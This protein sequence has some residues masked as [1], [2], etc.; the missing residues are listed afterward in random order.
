MDLKRFATRALYATLMTGGLTLLGAGVA[1]AAETGGDD[2]IASGTQT[3]ISIDLPIT[4]AGNGLSVLGDSSSSGAETAT[5][6]DAQAAS[7]AAEPPATSGDDGVGSGTQAL[8]DVSIPVTLGG[9]AISVLG[10]SASEGASTA[11]ATTDTEGAAAGGGEPSGTSGDDAVLG[12]TQVL[13]DVTLPVTVGGNAI[14]VLGDSSSTGSNS[15]VDG[16]GD[17][18]T[19]GATTGGSEAVLGGTQVLP[20]VTL[21][22]TVGGNA[23]SIVGDAS[24]TGSNSTVDGPGD[25]ATGGATTGGSEAVLGGTQVLPDVTLPVTVGGNAVSIVGDS[26]STGSNSTVDGPGDAATGGATTGG[27]DGVLGGTQLIPVVDVPITI[28]GNAISVLGDSE[29]EAPTTVVVP[30]EPTQPGTPVEPG[31]PVD[32][33]TPTDP[34]GPSTPAEPIVPGSTTN[35]GA[36][37]STASVAGIGEL[38]VIAAARKGVLASTGSETAALGVAGGL[39]LLAGLLLVGFRRFAARN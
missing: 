29:T 31:T 38:T 2:G 36:T 11:T 26:S 14:S 4:L 28:G 12:G 27:S 33:G 9:N 1:H 16:P 39:V 7:E 37:A 30:A 13:P 6:G 25:A 17:A 19:G 32:P 21:P 5:G 18:A 34:V 20:D 22:V 24:S 10:D 35:P 8:V 23:V 3:G 15:T